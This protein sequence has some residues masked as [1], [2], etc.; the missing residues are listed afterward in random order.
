MISKLANDSM[1]S[2]KYRRK[3]VYDSLLA[4]VLVTYAS[5]T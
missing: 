2:S 1:L 4:L 5:H 3:A